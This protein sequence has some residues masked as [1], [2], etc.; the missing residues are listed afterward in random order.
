MAANRHKQDVYLELFKLS[1][2]KTDEGSF[3]KK[4]PEK[5]LFSYFKEIDHTQFLYV[6][7]SVFMHIFF[8]TTRAGFLFVFLG[9]CMTGRQHTL[10]IE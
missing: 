6:K 5:F 4:T 3:K 2:N 9:V 7:V 8:T 1:K 10:M